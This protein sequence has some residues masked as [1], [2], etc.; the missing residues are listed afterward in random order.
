MRGIKMQEKKMKEA[1]EE[2]EDMFRG[3]PEWTRIFQQYERDI[4]YYNRYEWNE[5]TTKEK[6]IQKRDELLE[7]AKRL[8]NRHLLIL[9]YVE[10][11]EWLGT[12]RILNMLRK[13]YRAQCDFKNKLS[14]TDE[15][16]DILEIGQ[17]NGLKKSEKS[18][19]NPEK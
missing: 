16:V 4:R 19:K 8:S 3:I 11:I 17:Y 12:Y 2:I 1:L 14:N 10:H 6:F 5:Y 7:M 13:A 9:Y 18:Q 15:H